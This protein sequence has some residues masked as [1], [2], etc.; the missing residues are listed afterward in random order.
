L[1]IKEK[2]KLHV[3]GML[4]GNSVAMTNR[5]TPSNS[6]PKNKFRAAYSLQHGANGGVAN[7]LSAA[8]G[9]R[10]WPLIVDHGKSELSEKA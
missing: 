8:V 2:T 10:T 7:A 6:E 1:N 5:V 4:C 9:C 3:L